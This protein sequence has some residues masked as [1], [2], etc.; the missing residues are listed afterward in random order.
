MYG[1]D[2]GNV[3]VLRLVDGGFEWGRSF[4]DKIR[5]PLTVDGDIVLVHDLSNTVTAID[6]GTKR[7][8]WDRDLD[9]VN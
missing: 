9:D 7:V 6:I 3:N 2:A 5:A 4:S 8:V 1:S